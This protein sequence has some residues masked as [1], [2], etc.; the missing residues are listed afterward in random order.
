SFINEEHVS[1]HGQSRAR[2]FWGPKASAS[3]RLATRLVG[4]VRCAGMRR[5]EVSV[6][7]LRSA[8]IFAPLAAAD[9]AALARCFQ[10]LRFDPGEIVFR[11]G[12]PG[13]T[14][15]VIAEGTFSASARG[16]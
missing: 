16:P 14:M 4:V 3:G 1:F 2:F 11:E 10:G 7:V 13:G 8:E 12:E 6:D 9:L 15:L 5:T